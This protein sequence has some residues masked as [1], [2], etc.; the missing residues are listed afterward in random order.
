SVEVESIVEIARGRR[1]AEEDPAL[2][3]QPPHRL[4][5]GDV[6]SFAVSDRHREDLPTLH[7]GAE[8]C[9]LPLDAEVDVTADELEVPVPEQ[10]A[11]KNPGLHQDLKAVADAEY[12]PAPLR[13][14]DH[15]GHDG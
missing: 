7:A 8:G 14:R 1:V 15:L 4:R 9:L 2:P 10:S 12:E 6:V 3:L 13:V 5:I 11:G